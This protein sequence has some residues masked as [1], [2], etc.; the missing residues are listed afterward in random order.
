MRVM[1]I[2]TRPNVGGPT[3]QAVALFHA[4]KALGVDTLLC[5]GANIVGPAPFPGPNSALQVFTV[6]LGPVTSD[7]DGYAALDPD[8]LE[9]T[10]LD[11]S[12]AIY[13]GQIDRSEHWGG[14]FQSPFYVAAYHAEQ[15]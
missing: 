11:L 15:M 7:D 14:H 1:R 9:F 8:D 3:T 6:S 5:V 4:H 10:N 13:F 12:G 2:L